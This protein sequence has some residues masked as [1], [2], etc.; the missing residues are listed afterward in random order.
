[1][2]HSFIRK[3]EYL[4]YIEEDRFSENKFRQKT[5]KLKSFKNKILQ[6]PLIG[7]CF[8]LPLIIFSIIEFINKKNGWI[9]GKLGKM[10][11]KMK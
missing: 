3:R 11:Q 4:G 10:R 8:V 6:Y 9:M 2:I 7:F 1:M 5:F